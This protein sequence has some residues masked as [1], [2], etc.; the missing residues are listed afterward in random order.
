M[1][2]ASDRLGA[3]EPGHDADVLV[4]KPESGCY[5]T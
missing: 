5:K 1:I 2:G 4:I 3:L